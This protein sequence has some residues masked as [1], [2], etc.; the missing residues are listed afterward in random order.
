MRPAAGAAFHD[1]FPTDN[2][3]VPTGRIRARVPRATH[4][5]AAPCPGLPRTLHSALCSRLAI[6]A[7]PY[8]GYTESTAALPL[9]CT[10]T[11]SLTLGPPA[12]P[13]A[14]NDGWI[15]AKRGLCLV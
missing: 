5:R 15:S 12:A 6:P 4:A 3:A 14:V 8:T 2:V 13:V 9:L 7:G 1:A 10:D 11:S